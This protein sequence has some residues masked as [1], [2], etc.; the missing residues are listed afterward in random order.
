MWCV[1]NTSTK[2]LLIRQSETKSHDSREVVDPSADL[3]LGSDLGNGSDQVA[4]AK[5]AIGFGSSMRS[6]PWSDPSTPR[7][8]STA[9]VLES[10]PY[11]M[12][13]RRGRT[14]RARSETKA[15]LGGRERDDEGSLMALVVILTVTSL[16]SPQIASSDSFQASPPISP[17]FSPSG[18]ETLCFPVVGPSFLF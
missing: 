7:F 11:P 17:L 13:Q 10:N 2:R 15:E 12:S 6:D 1:K 16:Q 14:R 9:T 4:T 8:P 5:P 18:G 3:E